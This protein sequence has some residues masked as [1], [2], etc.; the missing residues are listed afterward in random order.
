[1]I[2]AVKNVERKTVQLEFL[3]DYLI[4]SILKLILAGSSTQPGGILFFFNSIKELTEY[5]IAVKE[6]LLQKGLTEDTLGVYHSEVPTAE[7]SM[8]LGKWKRGEITVML[9][10]TAFEMGVDRLDVRLVV[11]WGIPRRLLQYMQAVRFSV[12][13]PNL[14]PCYYSQRAM[15]Q[16][17]WPCWSR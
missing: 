4:L 1:M 3:Y 15:L 16:V 14:P 12:F 17:D 13:L 5:R 11:H 2:A 6:F 9:A 10:T 7:R 8:V